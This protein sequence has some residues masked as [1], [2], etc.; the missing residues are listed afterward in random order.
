MTKSRIKYKNTVKA[1]KEWRNLR[2][3]YKL[4]HIFS[5]YEESTANLQ[6]DG[7]SESPN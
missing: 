5:K 2:E 3:K 6:R 1:L 4:D 7:I